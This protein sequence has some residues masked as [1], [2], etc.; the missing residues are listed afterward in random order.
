MTKKYALLQR[1]DNDR[2]ITKDN[3]D[4]FLHQLQCC[5]LLAL[6]EQGRLGAMDYRLAIEKLKKQ[7]LERAIYIENPKN[8]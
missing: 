4:E 3:D 6:K 7:H 1:I 8:I 2:P 5:L